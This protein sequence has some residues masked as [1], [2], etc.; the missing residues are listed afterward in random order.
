MSMEQIILAS[1]SL[2]R[3]EY[4]KLLGLPFS[5]VPADIDE[6]RTTQTD[7]IELT[8]ELS[9]KKVEKVIDEMKADLPPW[10]FGADTV[11]A[12]N[13]KILGKPLDRDNAF[14]MLTELSGSP[15][16]VITSIALYNGR[17]KKID[18]RTACCTVHFAPI[19]KEEIE[20][21]LDSNEW[22]GVAGGYRIQGFAGCFVEKIEGCPSTVVGL[23]LR[24]F[25]VMLRDNGCPY[26][27]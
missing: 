1:G 5:V 27:A 6:S 17:E 9:V 16:Q 7:P 21:Y 19:S 26:G 24:E 14:A 8:R 13:G 15:H 11:V 18:C 23:P 3:Q 12:I 4:F 22:Q 2:R 10:I 20:R 25:Y